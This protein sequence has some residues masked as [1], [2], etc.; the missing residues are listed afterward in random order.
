MLANWC[1]ASTV[2][3]EPCGFFW[4]K[5]RER[6]RDGDVSRCSL[7]FTIL[8]AQ[9]AQQRGRY[10]LRPLWPRK[11]Q[12]CDRDAED[13]LV[14]HHPR[15]FD[16]EWH[17]RLQLNSCM[18]RVMRE[19]TRIKTSIEAVRVSLY[20]VVDELLVEMTIQ[21]QRCITNRAQEPKFSTLCVIACLTR[22]RALANLSALLQNRENEFFWRSLHGKWP[23]R[24]MQE[25]AKHKPKRVAEQS[26]SES[27]IGEFKALAHWPMVDAGIRTDEVHS[28]SSCS[29]LILV[30]VAIVWQCP[31]RRGSERQR[32]CDVVVLVARPSLHAQ[33]RPGPSIVRKRWSFVKCSQGTAASKARVPNPPS[34]SRRR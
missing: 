29:E 28:T 5:R 9:D 10:G 14:E 17:D 7:N 8:L 1:R 23:Y 20:A 13:A 32:G 11:R 4:S 33:V 26:A 27:T 21:R 30:R 19:H 12:Q 16:H 31:R 6:R 18:S 34:F 3:R 2:V 24:H 15:E 22:V 25:C